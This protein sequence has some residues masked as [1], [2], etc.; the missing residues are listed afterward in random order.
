[1]LYRVG[2]DKKYATFI[3]GQGV[4]GFR[5]YVDYKLVKGLFVHAEYEK[6]ITNEHYAYSDKLTTPEFNSAYIGLG[7]RYPI[8][9]KIYGS[10]VALYKIEMDEHLTGTTKFNLRVIFEYKT[11]KV[12]KP[13]D[14]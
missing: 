4:Y 13:T 1:M 7:K 3:S 12:R 11:K 10:L 14:I 2:F 9:R 5:S 6:I 8:S